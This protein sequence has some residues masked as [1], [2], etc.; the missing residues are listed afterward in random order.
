MDRIFT[1]LAQVSDSKN[2]V[3]V[4]SHNPGISN[5]LGTVT[6][7]DTM[8]MPTGSMAVVEVHLR[9]WKDIISVKHIGR[10][11]I[12]FH[13]IMDSTM[14]KRTVVIIG[15]GFEEIELV[16]PVDML[17]RAGG[18]V[19]ILSVDDKVVTGSNN[20]SIIADGLLKDYKYD[21]PS[22]ILIPGGSWVLKARYNEDI[23]NLV[24]SHYGQGLL[25]AAIC[26][27]P[28]ILSD[29]GILAGH[30]Y[31]SHCSV[32]LEG[33]EETR[34][35]VVDRNIIT[36]RGAG[37][38]IEFATAVVEKLYGQTTAFSVSNAMCITMAK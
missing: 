14:K 6:G 32:K 19:K 31:T 38:A 37:A 9:H 11:L 21:K 12:F 24:K 35:V 26:A 27:A 7:C 3:M 16:A 36:G 18:D 10:Q 22:C 17:R 28:L 34:P 4:I 29:A 1:A 33:S 15:N 2:S 13:L 30:E 20:I 23:L 25:T 8:D 5:F